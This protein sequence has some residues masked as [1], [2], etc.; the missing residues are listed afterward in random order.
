MYIYI[1][2]YNNYLLKNSSLTEGIRVRGAHLPQ[3]TFTFQRREQDTATGLTDTTE[4]GLAVLE[5]TN[6]EDGEGELDVP[7]MAR[8]V[9]E[10]AFTGGAGG[11][12]VADA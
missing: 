5:E 12:F 7:E 1:Y 10:F 8:A 9:G 11:G 3:E 2:I 6:V 4:E